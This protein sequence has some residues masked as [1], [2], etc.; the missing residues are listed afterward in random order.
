MLDG[1]RVFAKSWPGKIMGAFLL[2]GVAGFGINNVIV[3]LG[4]NTVA[5]VGDAE[6][7]SRQF[8]RAYQTQLNQIT[9]QL[10]S[11][12]TTSQ[13]EALGLPTRVLLSLS[14][15]ATL[16]TLANRFGLGVSE[17]KLAQMLR[18]DPSFH[19][20][21]GTFDPEIFNQVLQ[22][23]GWTEAEY[24]TVRANEAKREQI[25][26]TLMAE[27]NLPAVARD[28]ISNYATATRAIDYIALNETNVEAPA[29]PTEEELAAY[30]T[31]H[32]L[33]FRTVETRNVK[34]LNLSIPA[35]A[36]TK[37]F[38]DATIT[39][40][41]E[42]IKGS[43]TTPER[44]TIQQ[45]ALSTP[46]LQAQFAEAQA[47][48][49]DFAALVAE[50]GVTP[51]TIGTLTRD[52]VTDP[53]LAAAAF[54]L[55]EGGFTIISGIGG[56]RAIHVPEIQPESQQTLEEVRDDIVQRLGT[57]EAR[58]EINDILDQV[59]ELRA[60]FQP[61]EDIGARFNLPVYEAAVTAGGAQLSVM[62]TV[63][64]TDYARISQA[65][66]NAEEE[67]L[68]PAVSLG[69]NAHVWFDLESIEPARDRT[70][71]EVRD[72]VAAALR[73]ERTNNALLALSE[74][75]VA[76]LNAGEALADIA[77]ELNS[78]PQISSPFTRFGADDG[79]VD[80][81]VAAAAFAGGPESAG[82]VVSESGEFL[83]F[84]VVDSGTTAEPLTAD[85]VEMI[86]AEARNGLYAE[87]VSALRNDAGLR[88]NDQAL[89]QLLIQNFGE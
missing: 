68:T 66:F 81:T 82:S 57:A 51:S 77:A 33:E 9:G 14:E 56:Q 87:L 26:L 28:L 47:A 16:E 40:E 84:Q 69:G 80:P 21:L 41:Y 22:N 46:E 12:P 55:E 72:D 1:L 63:A 54:G 30:L 49:T 52:Q 59:E 73:A 8:L 27:A 75:I 25:M 42:A 3:D 38:D 10:G 23:S 58:T 39:A 76:R 35:L 2:V 43:L 34:L 48:G 70:L 79:S 88:V 6:I 4:S 19:G 89:R 67:K 31:E 78:F 32:Q 11:V 83:V 37:S 71:D 18:Q 65:I 5:R 64:P 53:T 62:P 17:A 7:N 45:V 50:A 86:N 29:E 24:F 15:G 36:A 61:L 60:A 85:A 74:D 44:R 13:A 20:T